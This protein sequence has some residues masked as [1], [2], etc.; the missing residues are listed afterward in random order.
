MSSNAIVM[1][2]LRQMHQQLRII[3]DFEQVGEREHPLGSGA[4]TV[5]HMISEVEAAPGHVETGKARLGH[6]SQ[7][8]VGTRENT[9]ITR[10]DADITRAKSPYLR[11]KAR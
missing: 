10:G 11:L 5:H 3:F 7:K 4:K 8:F 6:R 9:R 1:P 2:E